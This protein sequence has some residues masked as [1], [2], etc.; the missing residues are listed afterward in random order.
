MSP[1]SPL[2]SGD[3]YYG[4]VIPEGT[5][6]EHSGTWTLE[7]SDLFKDR[8]RGTLYDWSL[9]V[10]PTTPLDVPKNHRIW[11]GSF[12]AEEYH[13][14]GADVHA[15]AASADMIDMMCRA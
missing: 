12:V 8:K 9:I 3:L 14:I 4:V 11:H 10:N 7:I 2:D 6:L 15:G 1:A 13:R 5:P